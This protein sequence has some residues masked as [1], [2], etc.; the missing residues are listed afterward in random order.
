MNI[1]KTIKHPLRVSLMKQ[2]EKEN[3]H[4]SDNILNNFYF[5]SPK[6]PPAPWGNHCT[7]THRLGVNR[8]FL[9]LHC[10]RDELGSAI[11]SIVVYGPR[12][13]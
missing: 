10:K 13:M 5:Q 9:F 7:Q 2:A 6:L 8:Q 12:Q 1:D 3:L 4:N 11:L